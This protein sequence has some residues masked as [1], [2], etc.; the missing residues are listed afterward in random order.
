MPILFIASALLLVL[1]TVIAKPERAAVGFG[2]VLIGTPA[3]YLWR[4]RSRR[5]PARPTSDSL[6][7]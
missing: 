2:T 7:H 5:A 3:L 1:N 4:A 6:E